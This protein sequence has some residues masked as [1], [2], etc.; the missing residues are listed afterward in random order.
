[1][2]QSSQKIK[3]KE[4]L[5]PVLRKAQRTYDSHERTGKY[6][7]LGFGGGVLLDG[8]VAN[9]KTGSL[10]FQGTLIMKSK[11]RRD[12]HQGVWCPFLQH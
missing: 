2:P 5:V 9:I 1:M 11:N 3:I 4:P 7:S 10:I 6:L 8:G 12:N